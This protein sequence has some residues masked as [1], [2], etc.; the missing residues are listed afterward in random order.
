MD[1]N[2]QKIISNQK[3]YI[4]SI[5]NT[6]KKFANHNRRNHFDSQNLT[7]N[8]NTKNSILDSVK[9]NVISIESKNAEKLSQINLKEINQKEKD[10]IDV[11]MKIE[12]GNVNESLKK[13]ISC[14]K[15]NIS[16]EDD[17]KKSKNLNDSFHNNNENSYGDSYSTINSSNME[18][19]KNKIKNFTSKENIEYTIIGKKSFHN[20]EMQISKDSE[21]EVN[22]NYQNEDEYDDEILENLVI[23]EKKV[24]I[25]IDP[26]YFVFQHEINSK[27]RSILIDWLLDVHHKFN[28]KQETLY[29]TIYIIDTFLSKK[30]IQRKRFQLLGITSLIISTKFH[31]IFIRRMSD[32]ALI[33]DNAYTIDDIK[34]MEEE[35]TKTLN[36]NFLFPS[37]LSFFEIISKKIGISE[38]INKC[39]FGEFLIDSFLIDFKSLYYSYSTIACASSYIVMKFYKMNNYHILY[40]FRNFSVKNNQ[41]DNDFSAV[42][43]ECAKNICDVISEM[44]NSNL[45]S[46]FQKYSIYHFCQ[47]IIKI[48]GPCKK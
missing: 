39:K 45:Q 34:K 26:N 1:Q 22:D 25:D 38:D 24:N 16:N 33:T 20:N 2:T 35:I 48:L 18:N 5:L 37:S 6:K 36:F 47:G 10:N 32:Y 4:S 21:K 19:E 41:Y 3:Q 14:E 11:E 30:L 13:S 12:V 27:M 17:C 44:I 29:M 23:E 8:K 7:N 28:F 46:V 15:M 9:K 42:I 43:K 40:N 31:E